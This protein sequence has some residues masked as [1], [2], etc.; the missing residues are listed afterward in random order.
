M[1]C[2]TE[3]LETPFVGHELL[4]ARKT[5]LLEATT[6]SKDDA[7]DNHL[8]YALTRG[9]DERADCSGHG[10]EHEKPSSAS[11]VGQAATDADNDCGA[12]VPTMDR[13]SIVLPILG[14]G[15]GTHVIA[16]QGY[17][18]SGPRSALM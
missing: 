7:A 3:S 11:N 16:I 14:K 9:S 1:R 17:R 5:H 2:R 8:V 15:W 13:V 10:A 6:D 18:A 12:E 4:R